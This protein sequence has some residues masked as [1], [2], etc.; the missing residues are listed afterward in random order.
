MAVRIRL[1]RMGAKKAPFYRIVVA[2]SRSPRDG[3]FIEEV[4]YY[5]PTKD[6]VEL[7]VDEELVQKWLKN[8]AQPSDTVKALLK[9]ANVLQ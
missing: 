7:K 5:D 1:K 6:P 2:D 4:G 9:K 8:G 3:K